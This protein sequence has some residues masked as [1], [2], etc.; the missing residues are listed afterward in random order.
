[1]IFSSLPDKPNYLFGKLPD[2][3]KANDNYVPNAVVDY[4]DKGLLERYLETFCAE[5]DA[6]LI[7]PINDLGLLFNAIGLPAGD[8]SKFV[9]LISDTMGNPPDIG[10]ED[11]YKILLRYI[12]YILQTKGTRIALDLY[13]A[14]FGY[15]VY[16]LDIRP[17]EKPYYDATPTPF[18]FDNGYRFDSESIFYFD[19]DLV[20][21]D[22]D[23]RTEGDPGTPWLVKLRE[24]LGNFILPIYI[25]L[26]SVT[27]HV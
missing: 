24:A 8:S 18:K 15:K 26:I 2:Y 20:I 22:Y 17:Y 3:F 6:E 11:L 10:S 27:Y 1:M 25:N 16:S 7:P 5:I 21:T 4:T 13:L 23:G 12:I 9:N 14:L 19:A